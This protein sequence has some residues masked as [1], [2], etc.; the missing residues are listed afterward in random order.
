MMTGFLFFVIFID[1]TEGDRPVCLV[2]ML[3]AE[4]CRPMKVLV[5]IHLYPGELCPQ[6][7]LVNLFLQICQR[8]L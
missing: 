4:D 6:N 2:A 5:L 3:V 1:F 7:W 8:L